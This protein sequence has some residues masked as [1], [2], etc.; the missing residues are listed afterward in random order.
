E[1]EV[2]DVYRDGAGNI[3]RQALDFDFA[4]HLIEDAARGL[5]ADGHASCLDGHFDANRLIERDALEVDMDELALDRLVLPVDDHHLRG[6]AGEGEIED[7]VMAGFRVQ[8]FL[9]LLGI[10]FDGDGRF[11]GSV[12]DGGNL[13]PDAHAA[14]GI[15]F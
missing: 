12:D 10:D 15:F 13:A 6:G 14:G 2:G 11:R 8:D 3:A 5:D 4:Q 1:G 9:N 7:G